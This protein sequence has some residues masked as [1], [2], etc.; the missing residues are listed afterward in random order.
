M[1][2]SVALDHR[3]PRLLYARGGH[4]LGSDQ[5]LRKSA[6]LLCRPVQ[7]A[8]DLQERAARILPHLILFKRTHDSGPSAVRCFSVLKYA[9]AR[10][11]KTRRQLRIFSVLRGL[12]YG[13]F[14]RF[15]F[16][17]FCANSQDCA[18]KPYFI[19]LYFCLQAREC[20]FAFSQCFIFVN[21]KGQTL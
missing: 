7:K 16:R 4:A 21:Q 12:P 1:H 17:F 11:Y 20:C 6:D 15:F 8:L 3:D 13:G 2:L 19:L 14:H 9:S 10:F 18:R 5:A